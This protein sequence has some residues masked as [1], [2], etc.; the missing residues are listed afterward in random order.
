MGKGS[1]QEGMPIFV[2]IQKKEK[3]IEENEKVMFFSSSKKGV[4]SGLT[5]WPHDSNSIG[6]YTRNSFPGK[7][8]YNIS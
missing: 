7:K 8:K 6:H 1:V 4:G 5:F 2:R 3:E